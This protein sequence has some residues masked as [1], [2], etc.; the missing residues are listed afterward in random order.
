VRLRS[1]TG[2]QFAWSISKI[3]RAKWIG[4]VAQAVECL[5]CKLTA[6]SSN[7]SPTK[8]QTR[9]RRE[10]EKEKRGRRTGSDPSF[11]G[12]VSLDKLLCVAEPQ[13]G[14]CLIILIVTII[15]TLST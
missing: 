9:S 7:P 13:S 15:K 1:E 2:P 5:L 4:G 14:F 11:A 3:T 12:C 10:K 6:L 8:K